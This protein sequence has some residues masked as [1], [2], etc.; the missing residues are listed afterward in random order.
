VHVHA[1]KSAEAGGLSRETCCVNSQV[2]LAGFHVL[3]PMYW[4]VTARTVTEGDRCVWVA[5]PCQQP[6]H[7]RFH[8]PQSRRYVAGDAPQLLRMGS[9]DPCSSCGA[10]ERLSERWWGP[11][12]IYSSCT[13]LETSIQEYADSAHAGLTLSSAIHV[14]AHSL[15]G[16]RDSG[17]TVCNVAEQEDVSWRRELGY[18]PSAMYHAERE[19]LPELLSRGRGRQCTD[20]NPRGNR[21]SNPISRPDAAERGTRVRLVSLWSCAHVRVPWV[22][23][24]GDVQRDV[25]ANP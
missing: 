5:L 13:R 11:P 24:E 4:V 14:R 1:Q 25:A 9:L 21:L 16:W 19:A 8:Q 22:R 7:L 10:S 20:A 15:L 3:R 6:A 18:R 23:V 12:S 17:T 2:C